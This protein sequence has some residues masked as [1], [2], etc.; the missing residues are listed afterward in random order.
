MPFTPLAI[1]FLVE[2]RL[3]DSRDWFR[4]N[5]E[6]YNE[7]LL[8]PFVELVERLSPVMLEIDSQ[9]I[10]EPR[11]DRTLSRIH[12]DTRFSKD[13]SVYR[14]NMWLVFM[15]EKKL[16]DGVPGFYFDLYPQGFS[17][18]MGY[19]QASSASM[20]AIRRLIL[21]DS[22]AFRKADKAFRTQDLFT[23]EGDAYKRCK[24]PDMPEKRREWLDRK[25]LSFN[26]HSDNQDVLFSNKLVDV[27]LEGFH[28]LVPIYK[29]FWLAEVQK[30]T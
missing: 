25:S 13:K 18:G 24:Y 20:E 28:A 7:V 23:M 3:Q 17:Y 2:N 10:T 30:D 12:R 9:L 8:E 26:H 14:D 22:L 15:R 6:R 16:Y 27:L 29:F 19:Y 5:K 1:E 21:A 11:V 4:E